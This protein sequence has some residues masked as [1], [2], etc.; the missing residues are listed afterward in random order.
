MSVSGPAKKKPAGASG[1]GFLDAAERQIIEETFL[2]ESKKNIEDLEPLVLGLERDPHNHD[3]VNTIFRLVHTIK[4]S[5][6]VIEQD[7]LYK[8]THHF[9]DLLS[10]IKEKKVSISSHVINVLLQGI[11]VLRSMLAAIET[12][13]N[14]EFDVPQ[15]VIIFQQGAHKETSEQVLPSSVSTPAFVANKPLGQKEKDS[16]TV[17]KGLLDEFMENSGELTVLRNMVNK[18]LHTLER[19]LPGNKDIALLEDMFSEMHKIN[20]RMQGKIADMRKIPLGNVCKAIPRLVREL[21]MN[22]NKSL[23]FELDGEDLRID[24]SLSQVLS[25]S[26]VHIIRNS[27]DHGIESA[28]ERVNLGKPT[29]GKIKIKGYENRDEVVIEISDDGRGIQS[30]KIAQ[31]ALEKNILTTDT[32]AKM[33]E[34]SILQLIF[35]PGFSTAEQITGVSGRGVGMDMVK[36][37]VEAVRG[38]IDIVTKVGKGTLFRLHLPVPKS[39]LIVSSLL[40]KSGDHTFAIPEE[41]IDHIYCLSLKLQNECVLGMPGAKMLETAT[42]L[43]PLVDLHVLLEL[44][45][46]SQAHRHEEMN[47]VILKVEN[48]KYGIIVDQIIDLEEVVVKPLG[49]YLQQATAF[50]GATF[51]GVDTVSLVLDPKGLAHM[52]QLQ[53]AATSTKVNAHRE[54]FSDLK[55]ADAAYVIFT[56]HHPGLFAIALEAVHRLEVFASDAISF[57]CEQKVVKYQNELMKIYDFSKMSD[58]KIS[59]NS[60]VVA[61]DEQNVIVLKHQD[62]YFGIAVEQFIDIVDSENFQTS[63]HADMPLVTGSIHLKNGQ[64]AAVFEGV[65]LL[66]HAGLVSETEALTTTSDGDGAQ[67]QID[68]ADDDGIIWVA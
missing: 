61:T 29:Q 42:G 20:N 45:G 2:A 9:E 64:V 25:D 13:S 57:L 4:G 6:G 58:L 52:S 44:A 5:S 66:R 18:L 39:V 46:S 65:T 15:L 23:A 50:L 62:C 19:E 40:V 51:L 11:D 36:T 32:L 7:Y 1:L 14:E 16:L 21:S 49:R 56:A 31:K 48:V 55:C 26:L 17:S 67:A 10:K 59:K 68:A 24:T 41:S 37:S 8:Y 63:R 34:E 60:G 22:L 47:V 54:A 3:A 43:V 53:V 35:A 33:S 12:K 27:A 38:H 28:P 30:K